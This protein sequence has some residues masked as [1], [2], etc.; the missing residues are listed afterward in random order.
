MAKAATTR[1][2]VGARWA[3]L[4]LALAPACVVTPGEQAARAD[5]PAS[6][7]V[8]DPPLE[9]SLGV[10]DLGI[11]SDLDARVQLALPAQ[12]A[13]QRVR[14]AVDRARAQLVLY[15]ADQ[16]IKAYPLG[17]AAELRVGPVTLAL[18]PGDARE[19]R[20]LLAVDRLFEFERAVE[21]PPGDADGDGLPDPLDILIGAR[22]TALNADRYDGRYMHMSYP[23]GDVPREIG[24]C[25]D[26]IVRSLRN[27]GYDLQRLVHEDI[28]QARQAYPMVSKPNT[29]IDHR[30][31]KSLLPYFQR[32]ADVLAEPRDPLRPGD[33]IFM[34]T[35]PDRPG[36]EHV[37]I[38]ADAD[39]GSG[40]PLV[41][42]N[43][44]EGTVTKPMDLLSFVPVTQRYRMPVGRDA[45]DVASLRARARPGFS[46][47][48]QARARGARPLRLWLGRRAARRGCAAG[49]ERA[50]QARR[51]RALACGRVR[52]RPALRVRGASAG[53][54][55]AVR[56]SGRR[57]ALRR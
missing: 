1:G 39:G 16:P 51:R 7:A 55:P 57:P 23:G 56:E 18:R 29:D 5:A 14:A 19:L 49:H 53:V 28:L 33:V 42:N 38:L 6:R 37:G 27:A 22:K 4:G 36:S 43:W 48:R 8:V 46:S 21:L 44:T 17:G 9:R 11:Y 54:E 2:C 12:L 52:H 25:T 34:D 24:V 32:K 30:R 41:I 45:R 20:P 10:R 47:S 35:F 40:R 3:W 13:A 50:T 15:D 31:V 26:V